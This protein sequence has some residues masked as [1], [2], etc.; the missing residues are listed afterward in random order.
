MLLQWVRPPLQCRSESGAPKSK[1][2]PFLRCVP[3][4]AGSAWLTAHVRVCDACGR[5]CWP[6]TPGMRCLG[7]DGGVRNGVVPPG[8]CHIG[9]QWWRWCLWQWGGG[10]MCDRVSPSITDRLTPWV[11]VTVRGYRAERRTPVDP[12]PPAASGASGAACSASPVHSPRTRA[13]GPMPKGCRPWRALG[14][15]APQTTL[16]I[17]NVSSANSYATVN[18]FWITGDPWGSGSKSGVDYAIWRFYVDGGSPIV[19]QT[20]QVCTGD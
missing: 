3:L 1:S 8:W 17:H 20:S 10:W 5:C 11:C 15:C 9:G 18:F 4:R 14:L 13:R 7:G 16:L 2:R 6:R 19:L 12:V